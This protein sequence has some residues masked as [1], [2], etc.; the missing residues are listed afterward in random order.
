MNT[1]ETRTKYIRTIWALAKEL[2]INEEYLHVL[3]Y[4]LTEKESIASLSII[5]LKKVVKHLLNEKEKR[6]REF[7]KAEKEK[8]VY[9]LP[10]PLQR[11][12]LNKAMLEVREILNLRDTEAYLNSMTQRMYNKD[13]NKLDRG[14]YGNLIKQILL[15]TRRKN[16]NNTTK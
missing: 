12:T 11:Y 5:E 14:E 8:N 4:A 10:T 9:R 3:V 16:A 2:Q 6:N 1:K 15:I 13:L 7:K